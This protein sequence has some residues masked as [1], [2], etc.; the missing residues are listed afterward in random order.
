M[1][2]SGASRRKA[3]P[4]EAARSENDGAAGTCWSSFKSP[5]R[6]TRY[7][8]KKLLFQWANPRGIAAADAFIAKETDDECSWMSAAS[9]KPGRP[10]SPSCSKRLLTAKDARVRAYGAHVLGVWQDAG[11]LAKAANDEHPRVRLEAIVASARMMKPEAITMAAQ[12]LDHPTDKFIDYALKQVVKALKPQS[13]PCWPSSPSAATR[14]TRAYVKQ[15]A[16]A[17]PSSRIRARPCM[18]R[19]A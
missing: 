17:A 3:A 2:A 7:Q 8:A 15:I 16:S 9:T 11:L 12:V 19:S 14:S 5:E 4:G 6:W 1:A 10:R 18:T 13:F